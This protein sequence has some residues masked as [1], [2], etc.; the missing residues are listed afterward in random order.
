MSSDKK[1]K[2]YTLKKISLEE[3]KYIKKG[4]VIELTQAEYDHYT[5]GV[6]CVTKDIPKGG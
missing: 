2:C 5:K 6:K 4:S 1:V 3:G